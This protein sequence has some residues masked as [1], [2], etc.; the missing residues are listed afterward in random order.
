VFFLTLLLSQLLTNNTTHHRHQHLRHH[1]LINTHHHQQQQHRISSGM[2]R[3]SSAVGGA[4]NSS[5]AAGGGGDAPMTAFEKM[6]AKKAAA[7]TASRLKV[8]VPILTS[9][10]FRGELDDLDAEISRKAEAERQRVMEAIALTRVKRE[11]VAIKLGQTKT[12]S[13]TGNAEDGI[14]VRE[15][16]IGKV[17]GIGNCL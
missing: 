1:S 17:M 8:T 5:G 14:F 13:F 15:L 2:T 3:T 10:L 16:V 12:W 9:C 7:A 6:K 11:E 4:M